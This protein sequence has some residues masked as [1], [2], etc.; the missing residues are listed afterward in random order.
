M[1]LQGIN[2]SP[3]KPRLSETNPRGNDTSYSQE[4][5]DDCSVLQLIDYRSS[6]NE[7]NQLNYIDSETNYLDQGAQLQT[8]SLQIKPNP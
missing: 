5:Q 7:G 3:K 4:N 6:V 8:D 2:N 1:D